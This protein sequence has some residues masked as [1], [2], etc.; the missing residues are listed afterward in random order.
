MNSDSK[1]NCKS[2]DWRKEKKEDC[3]CKEEKKECCREEKKEVNEV[4][5]KCGTPGSVN[6]P[7][8]ALGGIFTPVNFTV[9]TVT[10]DT[11]DVVDP[12]IKF[13]V[14]SNVNIT[15]GVGLPI[16]LNF[17]IFKTCR[18]QLTPIPVGPV[19]TFSKVASVL[20]SAVVSFSVCDCNVCCSD[21]CCTYSLVVTV[22]TIGVALTSSVTN[23]AITAIVVENKKRPHCC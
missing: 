14:S 9:S 5:L 6:L 10:V 21:D 22:A 7:V 19:Y 16:T 3:G 17:Q 8:L 4:L 12:C 2:E 11:S 20:E 15:V 23:A 13:E 18:N 1:C